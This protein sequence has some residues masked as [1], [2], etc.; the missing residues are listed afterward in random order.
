MLV[1]DLASIQLLPLLQSWQGRLGQGSGCIMARLLIRKRSKCTSGPRI[2]PKLSVLPTKNGRH[3]KISVGRQ[4]A[5]VEIIDHVESPPS[6]NVTTDDRQRV[7]KIKETGAED[8]FCASPKDSQAEDRTKE[9]PVLECRPTGQGEGTAVSSEFSFGHPDDSS[10]GEDIDGSSLASNESSEESD[11]DSIVDNDASGLKTA[12]CISMGLVLPC[13]NAA[14][15]PTRHVQFEDAERV[16]ARKKAGKVLE[17]LGWERKDAQFR[18]GALADPLHITPTDIFIILEKALGPK[19]FRLDAVP[20]KE[21]VTSLDP[22]SGTCPSYIVQGIA[23]RKR[24]NPKRVNPEYPY[25]PEGI[26]YLHGKG[27]QCSPSRD[28][29]Y[30]H[31]IVVFKAENLSAGTFF[32]PILSNQE[33]R[34]DIEMKPMT[35]LCL[36]EKTGQPKYNGFMR[37]IDLVLSLSVTL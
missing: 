30:K 18:L 3:K 22:H 8:R 5:G 10:Q 12:F 9:P 4:S 20:V 35:W 2:V 6:S 37:S 23:N 25:V 19:N 24:F 21:L 29:Q 33:D 13:L 14:L 11:D 1:A 28:H 17:T 32:C 16:L 7:A 27:K 34:A 36:D 15:P 26:Q 31:T